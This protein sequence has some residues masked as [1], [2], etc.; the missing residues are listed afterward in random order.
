MRMSCL[1]HSLGHFEGMSPP[2]M[3]ARLCEV[4][5][6]DPVLGVE[7]RAS[8]W[9]KQLEGQDLPQYVERMR[10]SSE[11]GG[12]IEIMAYCREFGRSVNVHHG[13][14]KPIEFVGGEPARNVHWTGG[15]YTPM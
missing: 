9:V 15:H 12:A 13:R 8:E 14:G 5:A 2:S 11:W 1:F 10:R 6:A 4:L 3:R 7:Q